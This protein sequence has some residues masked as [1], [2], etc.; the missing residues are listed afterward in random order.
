MAVV[1]KRRIEIISFERERLIRWPA[2]ARCPVCGLTT[3]LLT[4][5][6]AAAL[7]QV[8]AESVRRWLAQGKAHGVKTSGGQYRI[9]KNSLFHPVHF[10]LLQSEYHF[11]HEGDQ[12]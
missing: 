1:R 12:P 4:S 3:E 7:V 11:A 2:P 5:R 6:Q 10:P 9:C 8:K